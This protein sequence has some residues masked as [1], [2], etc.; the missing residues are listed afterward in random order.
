MKRRHWF[1]LGCALGIII[2]TMFVF[3]IMA[4]GKYVAASLYADF[5]SF[6]NNQAEFITYKTAKGSQLAIFWNEEAEYPLKDAITLPAG[7][8]KAV[9]VQ[10]RKENK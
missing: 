6:V 8:E 7:K 4:Y 5:N 3:S 10:E 1:Y 9:F 2:G